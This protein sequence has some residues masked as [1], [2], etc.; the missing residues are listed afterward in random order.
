MSMD[1]Q[2]IYFLKAHRSSEAFFF[3]IF[4][5]ENKQGF[6]KKNESGR[7]VPDV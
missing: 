7:N 1:K 6:Q 3:I 2:T 4:F 5:N